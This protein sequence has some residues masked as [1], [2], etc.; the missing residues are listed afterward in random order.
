MV[1][2]GHSHDGPATAADDEFS[3]LDMGHAALA[4][5]IDDRDRPGA[6]FPVAVPVQ[7]LHRHRDRPGRV[8]AGR[9][10]QH[11]LVGR[12]QDAGHR[13]GAGIRQGERVAGRQDLE[14]PG[15]LLIGERWPAVGGGVVRDEVQ[16]PPAPLAR[17]DGCGPAE[18]AARGARRGGAGQ[19]GEG[20]LPRV[21]VERR[22]RLSA[23]RGQHVGEHQRGHRLAGADGAAQ[24]HDQPGAVDRQQHPGAVT[25]LH[26]R[27][28]GPVTARDDPHVL[29]PAAAG[30]GAGPGRSAPVP[31][32]SAGCWRRPGP[33]RWAASQG[34]AG[35]AGGPASAGAPS[36]GALWVGALSAGRSS[37]GR[38]PSG[39]SSSGPYSAWP[40]SGG[41]LLG[42]RLR[43]WLSYLRFGLRV[44]GQFRH[45]QLRLGQLRLRRTGP[46]CVMLSRSSL[47]ARPREPRPR[48]GQ[49]D[50]F[51]ADRLVRSQLA[52]GK[53]VLRPLIL[54][55]LVPGR[56][57]HDGLVLGHL[58]LGRFMGRPAQARPAPA[59]RTS[60]SA[61]SGSAAACSATLMLGAPQ[62]QPAPARPPRARPASGSA[63]ACSASS[64]SDWP[65]PAS[66]CSADSSAT[67]SSWVS[68]P[69]AG[70][71]WPGPS[72][73][74][75]G[76]SRPMKNPAG[77]GTRG[78]GTGAAGGAAGG[79]AA[80]AIPIATSVPGPG[81]ASATGPADL[82][83][84]GS[85]GSPLLAH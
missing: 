25:P 41:G 82:P 58:R 81:A 6:Q 80:V 44:L 31:P 33:R 55:S 8:G 77:P 62:A 10:D 28:A 16:V 15:V 1:I 19:A 11:E 18:Q 64:G 78:A 30:R 36:V 34:L 21:E 38:C 9:R 27:P 39:P 76:G 32:G 50:R 66:S 12:G 53:L 54:G 24:H 37:S 69:T 48:P 51:V 67:G 52:L 42:R 7:P 5:P 43:H 75:L 3:L 45:S 4:H 79:G 83:A 47:L 17:H 22:D 26:V 85:W 73:V 56:A 23:D 63:A 13:R 70:S 35:A 57:V 29:S 20:G 72:S 68:R 84:G 74:T 49:G 59:R 65:D 60:G 14:H 61:S 71:S 2:P 40:A 46:G